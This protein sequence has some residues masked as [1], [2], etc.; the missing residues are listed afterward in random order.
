[1]KICLSIKL[2]NTSISIMIFLWIV[3]FY[4]TARCMQK[5]IH[6]LNIMSFIVGLFFCLFVSFTTSRMSIMSVLM[7]FLLSTYSLSNKRM[8]HTH[9]DTKTQIHFHKREK[10]AGRGWESERDRKRYETK[11]ITQQNIERTIL[12]KSKI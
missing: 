9:R 10:E 3:Q 12:Y 5:Q 4:N 8:H 2:N 11:M 7:D 1:M 6:Y